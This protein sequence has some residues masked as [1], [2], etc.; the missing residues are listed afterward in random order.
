MIKVEKNFS[1]IPSI[2]KKENRE[3]AFN[4]NVS[5][6]NYC[7]SKNRYKV[8]SV[9][10][11]LNKIY[12]LKCAYC[13]QKLLD[14]PKHVEHYRPKNIYYWLA[15]SWDNLLLSCGSCNSAKSDN[16]E[17]KNSVVVYDNE[18]FK[19]I[20]QLGDAYDVAEEPLIINP[21]KDDVL[22]LLKYKINAE[23]FSTDERVNHTIENACKLN[24][25]ELRQKRLPILKDFVN[26]I[27]KHYEL[28]VKNGDIT[29]FYPD[30]QSFIKK[31]SI[32]N[33]FYSFR[34]YII[35]NL[36]LFFENENI[37]KILTITLAKI[38]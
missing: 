26:Q 1:D 36:N 31:V 30:V 17:I 20:H 37:Q 7:D 14:A 3:D 34:Y 2:L 10:N 33:E 5:S 28:F 12:N 11:R 24:R 21:E 13:E 4:A 6:R 18:S 25:K 29:R 22:R 16:F 15:Y 27:N 32:E 35:H 19:N 38:R 23:V 9:Q 8:G